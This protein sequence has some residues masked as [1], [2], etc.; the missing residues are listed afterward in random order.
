MSSTFVTW[1]SPSTM[2]DDITLAGLTSQTFNKQWGGHKNT[3]K[4]EEKENSA[5]ISKHIWSIQ[6][7]GVTPILSWS[8]IGYSQPYN[9]IT[10]NVICL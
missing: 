10:K 6:R 3:F 5:E 7:R 2:R 9:A 8:I 1:K 4:Y